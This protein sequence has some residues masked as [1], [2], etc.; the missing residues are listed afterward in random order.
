MNLFRVLGWTASVIGIVLIVVGIVATQ[1]TG[2][3]I[4]EGITGHYTDETMWYILSGIVLIVCGG[5]IS[6]LKRR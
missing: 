3:K 1:E 5:A 6:R 2:E 4:V